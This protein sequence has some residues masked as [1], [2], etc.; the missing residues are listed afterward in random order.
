VTGLLAGNG[1][2]SQ[3]ARQNSA[4]WDVRPGSRETILLISGVDGRLIRRLSLSKPIG[5]MEAGS[6]DKLYPPRRLL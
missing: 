4:D 1:D 5:Y 6:P 3:M 2:P